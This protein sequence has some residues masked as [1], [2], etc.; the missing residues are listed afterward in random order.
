MQTFISEEKLSKGK[1]PV[2]H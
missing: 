2:L 1:V